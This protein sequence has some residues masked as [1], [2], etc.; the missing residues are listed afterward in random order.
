MA[1]INGASARVELSD[2]LVVEPKENIA[3]KDLRWPT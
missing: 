3:R 2:Q 1:R